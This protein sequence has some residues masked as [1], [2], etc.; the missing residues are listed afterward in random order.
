MRKLGMGILL[1]PVYLFA[2]V[3]FH[4]KTTNNLLNFNLLQTAD[5]SDTVKGKTSF[6]IYAKEGIGGF[7]GGVFGGFP[8][9][10]LLLAGNS[11]GSEG[12]VVFGSALSLLGVIIGIPKGVGIVGKKLGENGSYRKTFLG[13]LIGTGLGLLAGGN[14]WGIMGDHS[15]MAGPIVGG[16]VG[17]IISVAGAVWGYNW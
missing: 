17:S 16:A 14:V 9:G 5:K 10:I 8:G 12:Y 11:K 7:L 4:P 6:S 2:D 13:T 1:L 3:G 15:G